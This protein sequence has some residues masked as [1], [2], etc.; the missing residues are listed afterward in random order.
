M[1]SWVLQYILGLQRLGHE[2]V[3][4][5]RS[6]HEN[7]CYDPGKMQMSDDCRQGIRVMAEILERFG[8]GKCWCFVDI[9]G[10][11]FGLS[12]EAVREAFRSADLFIDLG[13]HGAWVEAAA[14]VPT[15]VL[16]DGE[17]GYTQMQWENARAAGKQ[18]LDFDYYYTTGQNIGTEASSS[19]TAGLRWRHVFHPVVTDLFEVT[20]ARKGSPFTTVMNWV[21]HQEISFEGKTYFQ[22][23]KEF[24]KFVALPSLVKSPLELGLSRAPR[25]VQQRLV[26]AGWQLIDGQEAT[27][28]LD[29][30]YEH[31]RR[32]R[33]EFSV[34]KNV[35]VATNS[36]WFADRS[37]AYLAS[38]RPVVMQDTGFSAHLPCGEG[39][40]AVRTVAE[41]AEAIKEIQ[42][43]YARQSKAAREIAEQYL[44]ARVVLGR[45]LAE[46]G[47]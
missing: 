12:Q 36:G 24:E 18:P 31:I 19:P 2:V 45:F 30:F 26:E 44:D 28:S 40:F 47:V 34:C 41:A 39:L 42:H 15:R 3:F 25:D 1:M 7:A 38:G 6:T 14:H 9:H 37:A 22:K 46:V 16:I 43:S 35:F 13:P 33:G 4:V 21:S 8:L 27:I 11:H 20:D 23:D 29:R 17:P 10:E 32:S 5:E